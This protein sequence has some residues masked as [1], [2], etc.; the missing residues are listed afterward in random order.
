MYFVG[1]KHDVGCEGG[2]GPGRFE[3][4]DVMHRTA[5]V[6][7]VRS[8]IPGLALSASAFLVACGGSTTTSITAPS[9]TADGR[10][11]LSFDGGPRTIGPAGGTST[12]AVT[13]QRECS[14]SATSAAPWIAI[15]SGAQG[16]GAGTIGLR[17]DSN[18]DPVNRTGAVVI[19]EGRL[20][21]NQQAGA[22][23]FTVS[24]P[25]GA[26][27]AEGGPLQVA[28]R[29]H[30][31]CAWTAAVEGNFMTVT[32]ASGRGD[33]TVTVT[34]A[35]NTG[36]ERSGFVIA[37]G[38]RIP[39]TQ[40]APSAPPPPPPAPPAPVP[41]PPAPP[42]P[43]PPAPT[44]PAP[45]P[46]GPTPPTPP[47]PTPPPAPPNE[48][49]EFSGVV[50]AVSG[51]CPNVRLIVNGRV[52]LTDEDTRFRRGRCSDVEIGSRVEIRGRQR[53]DGSIRAEV[54]E[55]RR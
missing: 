28:V 9:A 48:E 6:P 7:R 18:P 37:A 52:V 34:V 27:T 50:F 39:I 38:E 11:Q 17:V 45:T 53:E 1:Q 25:Q 47:T 13:V 22:C 31:A 42:A 10:C 8:F 32:P 3:L 40:P 43:T 5:L 20:E 24:P 49:V 14:W 4:A 51:R 41:T 35:R 19:G 54:V 36:T 23:R 21:V 30:S 12:V 15:T 2:C 16:Q 29:T 44:P 46:P 55:N 26:P 33:G